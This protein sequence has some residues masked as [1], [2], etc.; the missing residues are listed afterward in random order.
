MVGRIG[1]G[2]RLVDM[3]AT[4]SREALANASA[5]AQVALASLALLLA[6]VALGLA[7]ATLTRRRGLAWTWGLVPLAPAAFTLAFLVALDPPLRLAAPAAAAI[8][9]FPLGALGWAAHCQLEDRRSGADREI[10][11]GRRVRPL[12]GLRRH[13]AERRRADDALTC[14]LPIG[15]TARGELVCVPRGSAESGA[16]ILVPG[17]TGAGKTT[18]LAALLVEYVVRSRFGAVVIEA[19]NDAA[20]LRSAKVAAA[21]VGVPLRLISP[22]GP[23]SYNPLAGGSV[24]E[25]SERLIAAQVWGSEDADFYRQAASPFLRNVLRALDAAGAPVTLAAVA[26]RCDP[27]ELENLVCELEEPE[28]REELIGV[29]AAMRADEK[30]AIVG[31]RARLR[32]LATSEFARAWLD[33]AR[34]GV[35]A[36]DLRAAIEA[37][38]VVY[39]RLDTDRTGNVGRTIAQMALLDLGAVASALMGQGVGTFV[40]IDEFGA[41]EAP[42]LDRLYTRGRAAG[43][44]VAL[45]TQTLADLRA[46]GPAVRE[47][48]GATAAAVI[49]H[50]IGGQEDAEWVA[51]AIGTVPTWETTAK[52]NRLGLASEEGTRTRGYRFEVNPSELQRLGPGEAIVARLGDPGERRSARVL[53][54]PPWQRQRA[55]TP[56]SNNNRA[57]SGLLGGAMNI[58]AMTATLTRDPVLEH[59]GEQT[60]CEMRVAERRPVGDPLYITV[61]AFGAE[62]EK[63]ATYLSQGRHV[64]ISGRL[65]YREWQAK[66]GGTRSEHSVAASRIEFLPGGSRPEEDGTGVEEPVA[67]VPAD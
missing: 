37:R 66:G 1:R 46:A 56:A 4:G 55:R 6:T 59:H 52:T 34:A 27:D 11:A 41:L 44:S 18:S 35:E 14:E 5:F 62:A 15:R 19:K 33:P 9:G 50:R 40:A 10:A 38:E 20:L 57:D 45:G 58:V 30:R 47:R 65:R 64:A 63:C 39:L 12:D 3:A 61:A 31:L 60:I 51:Q 53:V 28:L 26:E 22:S 21:A 42:A 67:G 7:A 48:I 54:V 23:C 43:F 29:G 25:R 32:N 13:L 8:C 16:H 49:C 24:D 17:A 2:R 36:V